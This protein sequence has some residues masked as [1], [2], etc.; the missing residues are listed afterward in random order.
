M[1]PVIV[2]ISIY[3]ASENFPI[4][5]M[6][7]LTGFLWKLACKCIFSSWAYFKPLEVKVYII[8][9]FYTVFVYLQNMQQFSKFLETSKS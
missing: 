3:V 2:L 5:N 4:Q 6:T 9:S 8:L 7:F 1:N